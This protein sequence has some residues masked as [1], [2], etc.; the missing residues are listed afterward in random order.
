MKSHYTAKVYDPSVRLTDEQVA[1]LS[2]ILRLSPSSINS[3]PWAF[4]IVS[5][6]AEMERLAELS[7]FNAEK[8]LNASHV[9]VLCVYKDAETFERE[10]LPHMDERV[11]AFYT[12]VLKPQGEAYVSSWM[13]RQVYIALG[14]L[15]TAAQSMGIDST[16]MEGINVAGYTQTLGDDRYRA[17]VAV[18][19][20]ARTSDDAN[21]PHITPKTR[22]TDV[23][24]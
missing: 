8:I 24:I 10:R 12:Q 13:E 6:R 1:T 2:E 7:Q 21:Q 9:V 22:R 16:P 4:R 19:L 23:L 14:V 17:L 11:T 3:Q 15:L 18:A 5:D 20:G